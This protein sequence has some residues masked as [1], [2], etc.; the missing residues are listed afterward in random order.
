M[1]EQIILIPVGF[2]YK[3]NSVYRVVT[4]DY[5]HP[6]TNWT[7]KQALANAELLLELA[8]N[9]S[10]NWAIVQLVDAYKAESTGNIFV[11][12]GV[13]IP[14][15]TQLS[16][17]YTWTKVDNNDELVTKVLQRVLV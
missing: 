4:T 7:K 15:N 10:A 13:L 6:F 1:S 2:S 14:F 3:D 5:K 12:Y 17:G 11:V 8:C 16:D 9:I